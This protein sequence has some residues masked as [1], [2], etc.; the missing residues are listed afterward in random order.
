MQLHHIRFH[1]FTIRPVCTGGKTNLL[2]L[3]R[4]ASVVQPVPK[5]TIPKRGSKEQDRQCKYNVT[6]TRDVQP[7]LQWKISKYSMFRFCVCSLSYPVCNAHAPYYIVIC[8]PSGSTTFFH[9]VSHTA[10][11][12]IKNVF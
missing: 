4:V 1:H 8:S 6:L 10:Q 9:I 2:P 5:V 11:F 3:L 7:L 12:S